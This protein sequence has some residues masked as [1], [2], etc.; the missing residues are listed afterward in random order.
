MRVRPLGSQ[1]CTLLR[2]CARSILC[3]CPGLLFRLCGKSDLADPHV[4]GRACWVSK[5]AD[6]PSGQLAV[7]MA[8]VGRELR[9]CHRFRPFVPSWWEIRFWQTLIR[10]LIHVG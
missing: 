6:K 7:Q 2:S 3:V 8:A 10:C 1:P 5:E 4:L 9:A